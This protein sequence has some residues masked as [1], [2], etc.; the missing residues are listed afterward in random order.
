[1]RGVVF[2]GDRQLELMEFPDPTPG[3][4]EVVLEMKASGMCGSDLH[5]YRRAKGGEFDRRP[6]GRHRAG[7]RRPRAVRHRRRGR[8]GRPGG[9]G[10]DRPARHGASLQGLHRVQP[11]P[12]RLVAAVPGSAGQGVRQ[13]RPWRARQVHEGAGLHAGAA[14]RRA[15]LRCRRG[16]LVRHRHGLWRA[17]PHPALGQRH[18]R[19]LRPGPGR[20]VGD[21]AGEGDGRAR[22]RARRQRGAART[23]PRNSAPTRPS[24][25]ARTTRSA[26]SRI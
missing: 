19:D 14:A 15:V 16:D 20:A 5:Q 22:H 13:Q 25:R 4:G 21:A 9:P 8:P 10:Q 7:D 24:T 2:F 17:A 11:L 3:E 6:A 12:L 18:D 23:A 1:M 26:R